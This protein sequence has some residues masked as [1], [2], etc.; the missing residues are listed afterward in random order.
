V[1][2][3]HFSADVLTGKVTET[4]MSV[5]SA[6][7]YRF[8]SDTL[9]DVSSPTSETE[10]AVVAKK[11]RSRRKHRTAA[12]VEQTQKI[13]EFVIEF[14]FTPLTPVPKVAVEDKKAILMGIV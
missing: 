2:G 14:A 5:F 1:S 13:N 3:F 4:H 11:K 8:H 12:Q 6:S 9:P 10:A 7:S